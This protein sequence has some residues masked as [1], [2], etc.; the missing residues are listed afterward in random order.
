LSSFDP[1]P[2]DEDEEFSDEYDDE[3]DAELV[4]CP[5]C[6]ASI[7]EES[8]QCPVCGSYITFGTSPFSG[9]SVAWIV[10]GLLGILATVAVLVFA[11]L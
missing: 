6:G 9:R 11:G 2:D 8:Q 4:P 5:E 3:T 10:L 1:L 7:Y